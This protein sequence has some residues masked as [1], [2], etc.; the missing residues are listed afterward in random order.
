M[1][2]LLGL[3]WLSPY[4]STEAILGKMLGVIGGLA[5]SRVPRYVRGG[6][7]L[8]DMRWFTK[9]DWST[10]L[11]SLLLVGLSVRLCYDSDLG[12]RWLIAHVAM[13]VSALFYG[14]M[15]MSGRLTR[16]RDKLD[17]N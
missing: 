16:F 14:G 3:I 2:V 5:Y 10:Y 6:W 13:G 12:S 8:N 1:F 11:M 7:F 15:F 17:E 9:S 4:A